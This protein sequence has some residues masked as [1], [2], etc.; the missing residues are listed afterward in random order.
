MTEMTENDGMAKLMNFQLLVLVCLSKE[1][2]K[3]RAAY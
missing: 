1:T 3:A 2:D